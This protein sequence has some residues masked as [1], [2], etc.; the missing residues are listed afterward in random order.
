M[1]G[2]ALIFPQL[3]N[4]NPKHR[5]GAQTDTAELK[6][7]SFF[8][9]IDWDA[10]LLKQVTPP[11]KPVVE[12]DESTANFD[13]E[14]TS[15][16]VREVGFGAMDLDEEDPSE[17]WVSQ[18]IGP[19]GFTH[20]PNG[21]L[22]CEKDKSGISP[23]TSPL[24]PFSPLGPTPSNCHKPQGIKIAPK[25]KKKDPSSSPL[26]RSVQEEFRG[27]TYSGGESIITTAGIMG[28]KANR[29][30]EEAVDDEEVQEPTTEDEYEDEQAVGRYANARRQ[31]QDLQDD[32]M[33]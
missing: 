31:G 15:A 10:L 19:S 12:S 30:D 24:T 22:G 13:P 33:I 32:D 23:L 29:G 14:F 20:T 1:F 18:S 2:Q 11:F 28:M 5:L 9:S 17:D 26:T 6:A 27:F 21:P 4:R 8:K 16:D 25:K 7:H 3:L